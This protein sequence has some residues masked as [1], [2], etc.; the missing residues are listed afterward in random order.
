M[1]DN[2]TVTPALKFDDDKPMV[3]LVEPQYILG[4]AA[5]MSHGAR[6]YGK[7][8]WK[9][10]LEMDRIYSAAMRHLLAFHDGQLNDPE[11]G[12]SH[13]YHCSAN[14]MFLDFYIRKDVPK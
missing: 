1:P 7:S 6:K 13:L 5:V 11:T 4:T 2:I 14:L 9:N 8:N 10:N 3:A 12:L